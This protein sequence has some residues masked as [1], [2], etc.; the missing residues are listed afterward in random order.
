[1]AKQ[2]EIARVD[3]GREGAVIQVVDPAFP[4]ERKSKPEKAKIA[5]STSLATGFAL[6]LWVFLR[7]LL[8]NAAQDSEKSQKL[9]QLHAAW[10]RA[11]GRR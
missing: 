2:Y 7:Q 6:L 11:L 4:P 1:M 10:R 3:E 9:K 5:V 8:R